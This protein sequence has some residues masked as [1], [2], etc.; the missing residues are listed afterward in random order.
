MPVR[1]VSHR[2][3]LF[4]LDYQRR[5]HSQFLPSLPVPLPLLGAALSIMTG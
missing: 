1:L 5:S 2:D 3:C 4:L